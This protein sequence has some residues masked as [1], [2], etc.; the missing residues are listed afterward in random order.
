[1]PGW[2]DMM[3]SIMPEEG[4]PAFICPGSETYRKNAMTTSAVLVIRAEPAEED[5]EEAIVI[6][7]WVSH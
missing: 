2:K 5:G 1:M 3:I 7:N 4:Q 6:L